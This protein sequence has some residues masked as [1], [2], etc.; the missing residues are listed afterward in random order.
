MEAGIIISEME[1][2]VP[3]IYYQKMS[4]GEGEK[5]KQHRTWKGAEEE[6]V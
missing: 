2:Q 5:G 6:E 1:T 3:V 4:A